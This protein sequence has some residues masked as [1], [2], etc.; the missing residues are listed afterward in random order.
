MAPDET[1]F[2]HSDRGHY[3]YLR[4]QRE[5]AEDA[6]AA[7]RS[8]NAGCGMLW[9]IPA[10]LA[11]GSVLALDDVLAAYPPWSEG[12]VEL[13]PEG[14]AQGAREHWWGALLLGIGVLTPLWL[15]AWALAGVRRAVAVRM[16]R[17]WAAGPVRWLWLTAM[18][19]VRAVATLVGLVTAWQVVRLVRGIPLQE[20]D[21]AQ[22]PAVL[23]AALVGIASALRAFAL[24]RQLPAAGE[25]F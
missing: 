14:W 20:V 17:G 12:I 9:L 15:L 21:Y 1:E 7:Q 3:E 8:R 5:A 22:G 13:L 19:A 6:A 10:L 16:P 23:V 24:H 11:L 25:R 4:Q 2:F 18:T